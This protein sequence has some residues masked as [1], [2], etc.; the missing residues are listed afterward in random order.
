MNAFLNH[1]AFEFSAGVRNKTLLLMNYLLPLGFF[2]M[3][4]FVMG[5]IIPE[6]QKTIVPA[7]VTF[8]VLSAAFLGIPDPL[9]NAREKGIFRSYK[10]NGVPSLS[11]LIIPALTT[12]VHLLIV[13]AIITFSARLL[14][15][16]DL[17]INWLNYCFV[18]IAM[19]F[20][21]SG[22]GVLI[23]VI[24]PNSRLTV[25]WA[26]L[27]Y[28]PSMLLGGLMFP[29]S[30]LPEAAKKISHLLP[31]THGMNAFKA[32]AMGYPADFPAWISIAVLLLSG[33]V[34]F[35]VANFL[36]SWDSKNTRRRGPLWLA[37]LVFLPN[38]LGYFLL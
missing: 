5:G 19:A 2:L 32:L 1:F 3:M 30:L 16:A 8:A 6:F 36:F 18:L 15:F 4:G 28:I 13:A 21:C 20:A 11:L 17:P 37:L 7:M 38:I 24:S 31:A 12:I 22:L 9:V 10:I 34:A 27:F 33:I 23:G 14:F 25:L 35:G 26:Q 29:Y